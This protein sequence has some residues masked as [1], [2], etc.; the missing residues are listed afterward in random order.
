MSKQILS[1]SGEKL[2][3]ITLNK[4]VFGIE[5]LIN[6]KLF[7]ASTLTN[8]NL[9]IVTLSL[10]MLPAILLPLITRLGVVPA[11]IE[12]GSLWFLEP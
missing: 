7:S 2:G 10:P 5:P 1:T 11:P 8:F 4:E 6:T 3:E 12:P 9:V